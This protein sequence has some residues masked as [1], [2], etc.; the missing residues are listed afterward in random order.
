MPLF[1]PA[2]PEGHRRSLRLP[3]T[4][5]P[6]PAP[7]SRPFLSPHPLQGARLPTPRPTRTGA[8]SPRLPLGLG[9]PQCPASGPWHSAPLPPAHVA[10]PPARWE[11]RGP[12]GPARSP[13]GRP[14]LHAPSSRRSSSGGRELSRRP[15]CGELPCWALAPPRAQS[16]APHPQVTLCPGAPPRRPPPPRPPARGRSDP[17]P[18]PPSPPPGPPAPLPSLH[19]SALGGVAALPRGLRWGCRLPGCLGGVWN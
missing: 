17:P 1:S 11:P 14:S 9:L 10:R 12:P 8:G 15:A 6:P 13:P 19:R 16:G 4:G 7:R 3:Q 18:P 2:S 5:A